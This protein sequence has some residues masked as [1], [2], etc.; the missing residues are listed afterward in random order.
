MLVL[1]G[2]TGSPVSMRPV[3]DRFASL[4]YAVEMPLLPGHGTSVEDMVPTRWA[5]W[6]GAAASAY[7]ALDARTDKVAVIGLSMGGGLALALA[8]RFSEIVALGLINPLVVAP[9]AELR[10]II[11]QLLEAGEETAESIGSDIAKQDVTEQGYDATPLR[12][13]L[14]LFEGI[15]EVEARLGEIRCPI[16]VLTSTQ[17]HVVPPESSDA[18]VERT[19]GSVERTYLDHSYHV[20]TLDHDAELVLDE[21][22]RFITAQ[23]GVAQ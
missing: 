2:F 12:A 10:Q 8:E 1:H 19:A 5:D 15:D 3:A 21:L 18:I 4:G 22:E 23:L 13:A 14:S 17:D 6:L 20:A 7:A 16:R 9:G 11:G